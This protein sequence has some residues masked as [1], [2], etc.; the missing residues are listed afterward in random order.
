[1]LVAGMIP[2]STAFVSTGTADAIAEPACS[3]SSASASPRLALLAS[4]C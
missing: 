1:M 3:T 4:A 2:L